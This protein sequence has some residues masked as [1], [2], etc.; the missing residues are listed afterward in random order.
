MLRQG[1]IVGTCCT[2]AISCLHGDCLKLTTISIPYDTTFFWE[3]HLI[4][5]PSGIIKHG[6]GT[7]QFLDNF[8]SYEPPFIVDFPIFSDDFP[9]KPPCRLGICHGKLPAPDA[10]DPQRCAWRSM[11]CAAA[12][13]S[14]MSSAK[15]FPCASVAR[16]VK[17]GYGDFSSTVTG[18]SG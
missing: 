14:K 9:L 3:E 8:P 18:K 2:E 12:V 15:C 5:I 16:L 6:N 1:P 7:S 4:S 17:S 13:A 11:R 10:A